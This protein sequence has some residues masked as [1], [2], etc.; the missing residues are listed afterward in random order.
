MYIYIY[1]HVFSC[2]ALCFYFAHVFIL[3][4]DF[5]DEIFKD[6][7][8]ITF[9]RFVEVVVELRGGKTACVRDL[10]YLR[11]FITQELLRSTSD[12]QEHLSE[13]FTESITNSYRDWHELVSVGRLLKAMV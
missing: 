6:C 2:L 10:H 7:D 9:D 13:M 8:E 12:L 3:M 1:I 4:V 5:V 11:K